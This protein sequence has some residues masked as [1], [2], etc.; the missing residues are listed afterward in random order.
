MSSTP[1]NSDN[2]DQGAIEKLTFWVINVEKKLNHTTKLVAFEKTLG[3]LV[4]VDEG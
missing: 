2:P 4:R 1:T 3:W